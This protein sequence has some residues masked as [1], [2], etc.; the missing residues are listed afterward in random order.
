MGVGF[1][2]IHLMQNTLNPPVSEIVSTY[3]FK[4]GTKDLQIPCHSSGTV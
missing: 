3:V 4:R 1:D 2:K